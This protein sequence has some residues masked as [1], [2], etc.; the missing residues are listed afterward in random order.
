MGTETKSAGMAK[1]TATVLDAGT[2]T[3]TTGPPL[4]ELILANAGVAATTID[5]AMTNI[6]IAVVLSLLASRSCQSQRKARRILLAIR[7]GCLY[8]QQRVELSPSRSGAGRRGS[9]AASAGESGR[10]GGPSTRRTSGA[11]GERRGRPPAPG[12]A[13]A[14]QRGPSGRRA[15]AHGPAPAVSSR[16][17]RPLRR[18]VDEEDIAAAGDVPLELDRAPLVLVLTSP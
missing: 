9:G 2:A 11:G 6:C 5:M 16:C 14:R 7:T 17:L 12:P 13:C 18:I 8:R 1:A 4:P 15:P 10:A 3:T